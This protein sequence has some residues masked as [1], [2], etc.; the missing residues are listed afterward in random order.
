[1]AGG[2]WEE[3]TV[4]V[5]GAA[6]RAPGG[7]YLPSLAVSGGGVLDAAARG[8]FSTMV[9]SRMSVDPR[10]ASQQP[11]DPSGPPPSTPPGAGGPPAAPPVEEESREAY[12]LREEAAVGEDDL[13]RGINEGLRSLARAARSFLLYDPSNDAIKEFLERFKRD[14]LGAVA[15][16]QHQTG[17]G[18]SLLVRPFELVW[19]GQIVYLERDRERSL[20]F[21]MFRDGVRRIDIGSEVSW[22]ELMSLLRILSIRYTGVRQQEEDIVTLLWKA[23]FKAIEIVAVEGFVPEDEDLMA[24]PGVGT[25]AGQGTEQARSQR[26]AASF[27]DAP[28]DFDLPIPEPLPARKRRPFRVTDEELEPLRAETTSRELPAHCLA[29][30]QEMLALVADPNDPT[31]W[32]DV[33]HLVEEVRDFLLA[34]GQL[35]SLTELVRS[36]QSLHAVAPDEIDGLLG[37]FVDARALRR[38]VQSIPATH[39]EL[40]ADL[41]GLLDTLKGKH[42]VHVLEVLDAERGQH[43]RRMTRK[44]IER[45][46]RND[47]ELVVKWIEESD[48]A[49]AADL[50]MAFSEALPERRAEV[51]DLAIRRGELELCLK[52]L[53]LLEP[54][55]SSVEVQDMLL[56]LLDD[57]GLEVRLRAL[58][59]ITDR[60]LQSMYEA[61]EAKLLERGVGGDMGK[62]EAEA[63]G[64]ALVTLH[65]TRAVAQMCEWLRP[66]SRMKRFFHDPLSQ[67]WVRWAAVW[68]LRDVPGAQVSEAIEWLSDRAAEELS[69]HC[70]KVL[71][72]RRLEGRNV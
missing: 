26:R 2:A 22:D 50:V 49:V 34:E 37:G 54:M 48:V 20:A 25:V 64:V 28:P 9:R 3:R 21:R 12:L 62:Q 71:A 13:A 45:F 58:R 23:G 43:A 38:I 67:K 7:A 16:V 61:V 27:V 6:C 42:L 51:I 63:Y 55:A 57:P 69:N 14:M 32:R 40:P 47:P 19:D 56:G 41:L 5:R 29:L 44:L 1:M 31:N 33:M 70:R 4:R 59:Q 72:K 11:P 17:G 46:A 10:D 8:A 60:K 68:G 30:V 53:D 52:A 35:S 66:S 18:I 36:L 39:S 65:P 24:E 15:A